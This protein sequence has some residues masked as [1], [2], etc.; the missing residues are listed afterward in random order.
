MM[1]RYSYKRLRILWCKRVSV[2]L[3]IF[4]PVASWGV[5]MKDENNRFVVASDVSD[6][7][8]IGVEIY[9]NDEIVLELFRDDSER[10]RMVTVFKEN[11]PLDLIE[12]SIEIFK[13]EIPWEF[14]EYKD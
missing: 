4:Q 6:R 14:I 7:D 2:L 11:V 3:E 13:R 10:S 1:I 5:T 12:E 9:C 8:G